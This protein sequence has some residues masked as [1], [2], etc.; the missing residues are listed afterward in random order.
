MEKELNNE[1]QFCDIATVNYFVS[2]L[3]KAKAW[4]SGLFSIDSYLIVP[5]YIEFRVGEDS[6]E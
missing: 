1:N 5:G 2:D 3:K 6:V 4:Y